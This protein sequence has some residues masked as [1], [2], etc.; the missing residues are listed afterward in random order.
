MPYKENCKAEGE[1]MTKFKIARMYFLDGEEQK[2]ISDYLGC[3]KNTVNQIIKLCKAYP[4]NSPIWE[5]LNNG[6]HITLE[7][8]DSL[9]G[10]FKY[11]S[12]RPLSNKRMASEEEQKTVTAKFKSLNYG[13]KRLWRYLQR[14]GHDTNNAYTLGKLKG[15]YKRETLKIKKVRTANGERR[16]LYD[17][18]GIRAFEYMQYDTKTI[19]DK[20]ALP[21]EIYDKFKNS[22][23]FPR[24]QWTIVDAKTKIRFLAWS[25]TLNSFFGLKFLELVLSWLSAHGI[26]REIKIQ[27]D[28]GSEFCSASEKKIAEWNKEIT[29]KYNAIVY[30]TRGAKWKQ[31]LVERTHRID[32]EEF[33][34]PR[35]EFINTET[36]FLL[37]AQSWIIDYN[38][39]SSEGIG[40]EGLSPRKKLEQLG[41]YQAEKICNFPCFILDDY[42]K[43]FMEI[44]T[45]A[46]TKKNLC[47]KSHYVLTPYQNYQ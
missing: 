28:G 33:Y 24:Y 6:K 2:I 47:P 41:I 44:L 3:H 30:D 5:Y 25:F 10:F 39:R 26:E 45:S 13:P 14:Q 9:F 31:N 43:S 18:E 7:L 4:P 32:D 8:L 34:C 40:M 37:E 20:H 11:E 17:Y 38:N 29:A 12:R 35:G 23:I 27:F 46:P 36:D 1:I 22:K 19:A 21:K 42:F 15:V 16:A